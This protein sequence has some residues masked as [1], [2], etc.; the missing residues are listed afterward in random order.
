[1]HTLRQLQNVVDYV[2]THLDTELTLDELA[3]HVGFSTYHLCHL[4]STYVGMPLAAYITK[5][6]L[7]HAIYAASQR[8]TLIDAALRYGFDTH[9]GFYK[10]FKRE[11][12]CAPSKFLK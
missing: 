2:E 1:M 5:R 9:A 10:A 4:F 3:R 6:R 8:E 11:F 12:G 7:Y